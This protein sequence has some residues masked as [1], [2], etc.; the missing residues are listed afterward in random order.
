MRVRT[1]ASGVAI[2]ALAGT[3]VPLALAGSA[4]AKVSATPT[5]TTASTPTITK[6]SPATATMSTTKK[7]RYVIIHGTE[8]A[9]VTKVNI[10]GKKSTFTTN[11]NKL[12]KA[13]VPSGITVGTDTVKALVTAG[14]AINST[15]CAFKHAKK[16]GK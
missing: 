6:C 2:A 8:L 14:T 4:S 15:S 16:T 11:T 3:A 12:I 10:D 9:G 13:T 5:T 7:T 1:V